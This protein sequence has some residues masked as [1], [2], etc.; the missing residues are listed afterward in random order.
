MILAL[1]ALLM[2]STLGAAMIFQTQSEVWTATNY[3]RLTQARYIAE[4]G[5]QKAANWIVFSYT[6]P[7]NVN[8]FD[9]NLS[10]VK[11]PKSDPH[12]QPVVLSTIS[13]EANY[14][15]ESVKT[16]FATALTGQVIK[17]LDIDATFTVTAT[18]IGMRPIPALG[19]YPATVA[20]TWRIVAEGNVATLPRPTTVQ[21]VQTIERAAR[22]V[23][24]YAAFA[25][26]SSCGV[27]NFSDA[28]TYSYDSSQGTNGYLF[29]DQHDGNIGSNGNL[30]LGGYSNGIWGTEFSNRTG[31]GDCTAGAVP[32]LTTTAGATENALAFGHLT[33][34]NPVSFPNLPPIDPPPPT[35]L[36]V[37]GF[38]CNGVPGCTGANR[39]LYLTPG[40]YGNLIV[41]NNSTIHLTAGTYN[42]NSLLLATYSDI[43]LDTP[44]VVLNLA[45]TGISPDADVMS[46]SGGSSLNYDGKPADLQIMYGGSSHITVTGDSRSWS[47]MYAPNSN[48]TV[49]DQSKWMGSVIAKSVT[50]SGYTSL[51][52]D[53]SLLNNFMI[54]DTYRLTSSN[55]S[56]Y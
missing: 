34:T 20:Q 5:A 38:T 4:A 6:P 40:Q 1:L 30:S 25:T 53:R 28:Y 16:G 48:T 19:P 47:V 51:F 14:P 31:S 37:T 27:L 54:A 49:D 45:G 9:V 41:A 39:N 21:V 42:I 33:L 15:D 3:K 35:T 2:L 29:P 22:S 55:W 32:A 44:G 11:Y 46:I 36:Q 24:A 50:V 52:Y 8:D 56:K 43:V 26:G 12:A 23:F 17:E 13:E 7:V 10:P 18:L